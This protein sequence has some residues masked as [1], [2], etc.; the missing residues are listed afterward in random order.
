MKE[1]IAVFDI[2][3]TNK[4]LVL[5]DNHFQVLYENER[6]MNTI[7]DEDGFECDDI[8][9]ITTWISNSLKEIILQKKYDLA[10]VNFSTYGASL[11]FLDKKENRLTPLYNYLKEI[12]SSVSGELFVEYDGKNEFCRKTASPALGALL[13]SGIQI[14]WLQKEKPEIYREIETILHFPQYLSFVLTG[15]V[16]SEPTSIGCHTFMWDFDKMDYHDWLKDKNITL[17]EPVSNKSVF[18]VNVMSS[19]F[20][21]GTGIHDSS[22]SL[23]PY[24]K[25]S[26]EEFILVSTGTWCIN[27]NPFNKEPL[28]AEQLQNDCLCYLTPEKEQ[29][30]SSRLFMGHFHENWSEKLA[31]HFGVANSFYKTVKR[32]DNLI[33]SLVNEY[34]QISEFFPKGK[35]SFEEGLQNVDLAI[36]KSYEESYTK[37]MVDLTD[38][39]VES[40][41]LVI[42]EVD[43]TKILYVTGGFA[44]NEIFI[45]LL[46]K[47]FPNKKVIVSEIDNA[48]ALGAALVIADT[49]SN[50]AFSE[51]SLQSNHKID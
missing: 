18:P 3:K 13:N 17:P 37:F 11:M 23:V 26:S 36:F 2:G 42:P 20:K 29:V 47:K 5:F 49:F 38:V 4:K 50:P 28:T 30:K 33:E 7:K 43:N 48:T 27:M 35:E 8:D 16:V 45:Y 25:G 34:G 1:V 44:R 6:K 31:R 19:D 9:L 46:Q 41:Q 12:P 24:L 22:A 14:L 21:V 39:C 32:N 15:K 40:I 10:G 51:L